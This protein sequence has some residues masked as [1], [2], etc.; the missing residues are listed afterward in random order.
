MYSVFFL[1]GTT[2]YFSWVTL[3]LNTV[4][5]IHEKQYKNTNLNPFR[6]VAVHNNLLFFKAITTSFDIKI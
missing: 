4:L 3:D 2:K 6:Y 5:R 1:S